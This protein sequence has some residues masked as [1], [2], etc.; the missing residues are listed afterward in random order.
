MHRHI[1]GIPLSRSMKRAE[2]RHR[3]GQRLAEK[4]TELTAKAAIV[5]A[6]NRYHVY[7]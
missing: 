7:W 5:V 2:C 3:T 1:G 4:Y 6:V